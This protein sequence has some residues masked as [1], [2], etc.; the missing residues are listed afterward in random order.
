M[1]LFKRITEFYSHF[2]W[3]SMSL[4]YSRKDNAFFVSFRCISF[5]EN[6]FS[7]DKMLREGFSCRAI[8]SAT[9]QGHTFLVISTYSSVKSSTCPVFKKYTTV[10][11]NCIFDRQSLDPFIIWCFYLKHHN[12][13]TNY[14]KFVVCSSPQDH[15]QDLV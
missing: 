5:K 7:F 3:M 12:I 4:K 14:R 6:E 2:I 8:I 9:L 13:I 10:N 1:W 15:Q 11:E